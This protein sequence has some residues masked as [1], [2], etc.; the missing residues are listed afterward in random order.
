MINPNFNYFKNT[1]VILDQT[2]K[3]K[4]IDFPPSRYKVIYSQLE[5]FI[6]LY[7]KNNLLSFLTFFNMKDY[8]SKILSQKSSKKEDIITA[9]K[10][11]N[12]ISSKNDNKDNN[13]NE[14][15]GYPSIYNALYVHNIFLI[16]IEMP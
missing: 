13:G 4:L 15:S 14:F 2:E 5:K 16:K 12:I 7:F 8:N 1:Y 10:E 3:M 9:L 6:D 11:L